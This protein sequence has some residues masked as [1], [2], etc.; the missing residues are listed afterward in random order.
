MHW[1]I[2]R[3]YVGHAYRKDATAMNKMHDADGG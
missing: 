3:I 2:R 1:T